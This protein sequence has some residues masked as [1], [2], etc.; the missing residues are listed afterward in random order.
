MSSTTIKLFLIYGDARRLRTAEISN[1]TGKALAAPRTEFDDLIQR[2][3]L[4]RTGVYFLLGTNP[5]TGKPHAYVGEAEELLTRLKNHRSKDFWISTIVFTSKDENLTKS[6]IRYLEGRML[7]KAKL[8]DRYSLENNKASGAK[9]PESD[10]QDMETFLEKIEQLLPVLGTDILQPK[11]KSTPGQPKPDLLTYK[12]KDVIATG[13]LT[14]TAF[15]VFKGSSAVVKERKSAKQY[16]PFV[17]NLRKHLIEEGV[18][19]V[20]GSVYLFTKDHEFTSP[21]SAA[22]VI[23]G[24]GTNG[25]KAWRYNDGATIKDREA[26]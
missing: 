6:H 2:E 16:H 11:V 1:W 9:L 13:Q 22:S 4:S 19:I 12:V 26:G 10:T 15:V 21:S 17:L 23:A 7:E 24:G 18:L 5:Q 14:E 25:L 3:E 20:Q 8:A